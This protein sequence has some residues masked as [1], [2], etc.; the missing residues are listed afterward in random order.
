L[1]EI[2]KSR[3][4]ERKHFKKSDAEA[5]HYREDATE[6]EKRLSSQI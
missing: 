4:D 3:Q 5:A 1:S 6:L 2:A